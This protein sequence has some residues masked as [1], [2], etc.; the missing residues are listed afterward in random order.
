[1]KYLD[2]YNKLDSMKNKE[3]IENFL[4]YNTSLVIAGVK[5]AV[6]ITI[7]KN[8]KKI[9]D[10]WNQ[11][12]KDFIDNIKLKSIEL[13]E[14]DDS[15]ILMI[16]DEEILKKEVLSKDNMKFLINL[17]Y[18]SE[19]KIEGYINTLKSRYEKYH[20]PHELGLFLGIPFE[21]VKD[22]MECT[23]KKCLLCGYWKVYN[24]SG[25]AKIIFNQYNK[26]KEY[27]M[28]SMLK[29]NLSQDLVFNIKKSFSA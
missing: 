10:N 15:I 26:V 24:N 1:M 20:C 2:F 19:A 11:F 4:V 3:Y 27:T 22:F 29:G 28:K 12:G 25:Q 17:G 13:R 21:D 9:Y 16:Y 14:S 18:S 23:T 7:K 8:N 6:T 5:P